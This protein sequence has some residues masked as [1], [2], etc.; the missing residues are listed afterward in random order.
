MSQPAKLLVL[1]VDRDDD[2]G[3]KTGIRTPVIGR[4][5]C[6]RA[7][8]QLAIA[9]PEEADANAIFAAIGEYDALRTKGYDC[10]VAIASGKFERG[11]EADQK[12]RHE[13]REVV[14][15]TGVQGCILVS[16]GAED[17]LVLPVLQSIVPV[18]SVRRVVIKHSRS[19]EESYVVLGRYL[20]MLV[21]DPRY[22]RF[23][24]G[25]PGA[26]LVLA[27]L[28]ILLYPS[29]IGQVFLGMLAIIGLVFI[30]RGFD[31]DKRIAMLPTLRPSS[32][33]RVFSIFSSAVV[34]LVGI[35][36]GFVIISSMPAY[37]AVL[38]DPALILRHGPL[39][40]GTLM[41][42][43]QPLAW[44]GLGL[45]FGGGL[46]YHW[47]RGSVK[48]WRDVIGFVILG[49]LFLP[50]R[51]LSLILIGQGSTITLVAALL[52]GLAFTVLTVSVVFQH[53]R[54]RR[55]LRVGT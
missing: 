21:Y 2:L 46:L 42:E 26:L 53:V 3:V 19:V 6:A 51:E 40:F 14:G 29:A 27:S 25:V 52:I 33:V 7:A 43:A 1:S 20:R 32:Y 17:E 39:L 18:V 4:E 10:E 45:Y 44:I 48:A 12:V 54:S 47:L 50:L 23:A 36:Q 37:A 31:V 15:N 35:Y 49:L 30:I 38:R 28:L 34:V 13:V 11:L 41:G 8:S 55:P 24:L 16:D 5:G 22:S 9:D